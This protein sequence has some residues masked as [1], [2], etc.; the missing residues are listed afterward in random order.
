MK[1]TKNKIE[2][3]KRGQ[4]YFKEPYLEEILLKNLNENFKISSNLSEAVDKC[5][6]IFLCVGTPCQDDGSVDL[7]M[8]D[9]AI[10]SLL[11]KIP[12]DG[13]HRTIVIKS[14]VPPGTT[15]HIES[16]IRK[17]GFDDKKISV[18]CNPEFLREGFCWQDFMNPE[19]IVIGSNSKE[20]GSKIEKLYS[21]LNV[22]THIVSPD[23]AEFT[24]YL[25]NVMLATLISFS[26]EMAYAAQLIENVEVETAFKILHEDSRLKDSKI[27]SYIYPGCGFGGYCLPKDIMAFVSTLAKKGYESKLLSA[28][29]DINNIVVKRF[30]DNI[31]E[32]HDTSKKIGIL[33]LSFK[34]DSDDVRETPAY[35]VYTEL[36]GKGYKYFNAYD[37]VANENFQKHYGVNKMSFYDSPEELIINSDIIVITTA[38]Q[39]FVKLDFKN[40]PVFDGRYFLNCSH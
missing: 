25:S 34:P 38:W 23:C 1:A 28:V 31:C 3:L 14:T 15:G 13:K 32:K 40:K 35:K 8:I 5:S 2:T 12:M 11:N 37:P 18:A 26:N 9:D 7:T 17:S 4:I 20:T 10:Q 36:Y 27:K 39:E 22:K 29:I 16:I 33:G 21:E 24:K 30:C 19:R 6:I